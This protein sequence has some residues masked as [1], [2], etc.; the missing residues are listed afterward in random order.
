MLA[1]YCDDHV[2]KVYEQ[3]HLMKVLLSELLNVYNWQ[4]ISRDKKT[5]AWAGVINSVSGT[6]KGEA[7][8]HEQNMF[9]SFSVHTENNFRDFQ[10]FYLPLP[11]LI[12]IN[13]FYFSSTCSIA[14]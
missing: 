6:E 13:G 1:F 11:Y 4:G 10:D 5:P 2:I 3:D 12:V 14:L 7:K 9:I 8:H